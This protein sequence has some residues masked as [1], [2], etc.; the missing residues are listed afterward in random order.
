MCRHISGPGDSPCRTMPEGLR[1]DLQPQVCLGNDDEQLWIRVSAPIWRSRAS[2]LV[3]TGAKR[4]Q[5]AQ[6]PWFGLW[7]L[8]RPSGT[9][10]RS[11]W[12]HCPREAS[13]G[14]RP[15]HPGHGGRPSALDPCLSH[16]L[17][18]PRYRPPPAGRRVGISREM[19]DRAGNVDLYGLMIPFRHYS[20]YQSALRHRSP[21]AEAFNE[22]GCQVGIATG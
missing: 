20:Y 2:Q 15:W 21:W 11:D 19:W 8:A 3:L 5:P 10:Q 22:R 16:Y 17:R 7:F 12:P 14:C 9:R 18:P 4:D 6:G 13:D 1:T